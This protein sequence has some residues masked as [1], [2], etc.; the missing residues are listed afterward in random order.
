MTYDAII[1]GAGAA[2]LMAAAT[3]GQAGARVLLLDHADA[4]GKKILISGG[5][6][7][8]FTNMGTAPECFLSENPHFAKSALSR[9]TQWDFLAL[10]E[11]HGIAWHEKTLGQLFCDGSAR[12]IVALLEEECRAGAV[13]IRLATPIGGIAHADG[14]FR[15][16]LGAETVTAPHLVIATGGPSIPKMGATGFAYSLAQQFGVNVVT[17]RPAL[18]PFTLGPEEAL[19]REISGVACPAVASVG[20]ASFAEAVLFTHKGLSGPAILQV[21]SYWAPGQAVC[22]QLVEDAAARLLAAK[23]STPR[24]RLKTVLGDWLP[25]RLAEVLAARLD[26]T[27]ELGNVAD[28]RLEAAAESLSRLTF[29]PTGTEGYAKAEVTAGGIDTAALSSKTMEARDVPGLYF[30]GDPARGA[31]R[32]PEDYGAPRDTAYRQPIQTS[33]R[34]HQSVCS[35]DLPADLSSAHRPISGAHGCSQPVQGQTMFTRRNFTRALLGGSLGMGLMSTLPAWARSPNSLHSTG[36]PALAGTEFD[37]IIDRSPFRVDGQAGTAVTINGTVPGPL[38]RW[39]EGDEVTLRVHNRLDEDTS[40][41]WHGILLPFTMDGVPGISF[42]GIKPGETFTYRFPV[43]QAGT[44]WYHSHSGLQEQ[45]GH[46]GA[47][48]IDPAGADPVAY[49]RDYVLVLSDWTFE[50]PHII[51]ARLKKMADS[52]NYG[53]RTAGDFLRDMERD[54]FSA[55]LK[56]RFM[57]GNMR[58]MPTD[59]ADLGGATYSYLVNGH[60]PADNFT[61]LFQPGERVRLRIINAAAMTIFNLRIPG[62][63][64][65][66]VQSDGLNVQPLEVD[67]FQIGVAETYDIVVTPTQDRAYTLMAETIDRTGYARATLASRPGMSADVPP[68]R[69]PPRLTMRDMGMAHGEEMASH[70]AMGHGQQHDHPTGPGVDNVAM[71]PTNRL[72]EPGLGLENVPHRTL[73]YSALRS[74]EPNPDLRPPERELEVHL[75]GNMERYMWSFDGLRFSEG[76]EP[77]VFHEGE[78]LR[79]TLVNDTMM[80]HPIHLHGMF[81]DVVNGSDTHKPRKHTIIVKPGEKLSVDVTADAVGDWA[82]HCHL[83]HHMHTG[84]FQIVSVQTGDGRVRT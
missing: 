21:S 71:M 75:T 23:R 32:L 58:M 57:W 49:D 2:G 38:L 59:I 54:G 74:L 78:R 62:L 25:R 13:E 84:M 33:A 31:F 39:R 9:Y 67:E 10:V 76:T 70:M 55:T 53:K 28:A 69:T 68:M 12:Q 50:N 41:H 73:T 60:G 22:L 4:P 42:P 26:I 20:D 51:A 47:L 83:L 35:G 79:L 18:V 37:L 16:D 14:Q 30:I 1:L 61:A 19:F 45:I 65:T 15:V 29:R 6:R 27:T 5:G 66:V 46:Y 77:I 64:M 34:P 43:K 44:Y 80:S 24:A 11:R 48:V 63:P 81:F 40:I 8:N 82:F 56:D 52:F 7:C 17:P 36:L 3:A 72:N